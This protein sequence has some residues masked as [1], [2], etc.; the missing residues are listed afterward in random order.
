VVVQIYI[1]PCT[2]GK[3]GNLILKAPDIPIAMELEEQLKFME[4]FSGE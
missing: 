4:C 1:R 3:E 2:E